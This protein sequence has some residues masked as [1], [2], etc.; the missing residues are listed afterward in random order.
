MNLSRQS[1][2]ITDLPE[3]HRILRSRDFDVVDLAAA[4][5]K[6][7]AASGHPLPHAIAMAERLLFLSPGSQPET[8]RAIW[9]SF[10]RSDN[11]R[12]WDGEIKRLA[13][14]EIEKLP[15]SAEVD[16][17]AR[18][19]FPFVAL[20]NCRVL[21][22]PEAFFLKYDAWAADIARFGA[23]ILS[24]A[25]AR[26]IDRAAGEF[27]ATLRSHLAK[28]FEPPLP[29]PSFH[30]Y[31]TQRHPGED[32][33]EECIWSLVAI[34]QNAKSIYPSLANALHRVAASSRQH[35]EKLLRAKSVEAEW[36]ALINRSAAVLH[37]PR[38]AQAPS[39]AAGQAVAAGEVINVG[40]HQP[41]DLP[42]ATGCPFG[43]SAPGTTID[44]TP[45]ATSLSLA[46]GAGPHR[47]IA[48]D[49]ARRVIRHGIT[50]L[51]RKFPHFRLTAPPRFQGNERWL[52]GPSMVKCILDP[53]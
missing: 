8:R 31:L 20:T 47:C 33:A 12:H 25:E 3:S 14:E 44:E 32:G 7:E 39:T 53:P 48:E 5:R 9:Y 34:H 46:F 6:I 13:A 29:A 26:R 30:D 1:P 52:S 49:L 50:A 2:F 35:R 21:G 10:F 16:L 36:N 17:V 23:P 15:A 4:L 38:V 51:L 22:L 37:V 19:V 18:Y 45:S 43:H 28:P 41:D 27:A 24:I 11:I 40:L 42:G